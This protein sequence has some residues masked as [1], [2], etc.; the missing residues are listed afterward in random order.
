MTAYVQVHGTM[1]TWRITKELRA[2]IEGPDH[3]SD[4]LYLEPVDGDAHIVAAY[5]SVVSDH[6][7]MTMVSRRAYVTEVTLKDA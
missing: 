5:K 2:F 6:P 4:M 7:S 3:P 1:G